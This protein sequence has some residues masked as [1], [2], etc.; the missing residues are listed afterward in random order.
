VRVGESTPTW[1]GSKPAG[2]INDLNWLLAAGKGTQ[3]G[4]GHFRIEPSYLNWGQRVLWDWNEDLDEA[5]VPGHENNF[6]PHNV[7]W[8]KYYLIPPIGIVIHNHDFGGSQEGV[9]RSAMAE[10]HYLKDW[11]R[12]SSKRFEAG[13]ADVQ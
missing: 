4:K 6:S 7:Y 11:M 9:T 2:T 3:F 10:W 13:S 8:G 5:F 1:P 12:L